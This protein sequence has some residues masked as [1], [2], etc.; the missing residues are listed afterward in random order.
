MWEWAAVQWISATGEINTQNAGPAL[1]PTEWV[2]D[3]QPLSAQRAQASSARPSWRAS[4]TFLVPC[5]LG[6]QITGWFV[7]QEQR[8]SSWKATAR[9]PAFP[10]YICIWPI[11]FDHTYFQKENKMTSMLGLWEGPEQEFPKNAY[12]SLYR[13]FV[14]HM[15]RPKFSGYKMASFRWWATTINVC[16]LLFFF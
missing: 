10:Y 16:F 15:Q 8:L 2:L 12:Y 5:D 13:I 9:G 11:L 1:C 3:P 14:T 4:S 6:H 7:A